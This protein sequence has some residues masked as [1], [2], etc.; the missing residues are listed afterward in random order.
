VEALRL[1]LTDDD[2]RQL[3]HWSEHYQSEWDDEP[4]RYVEF[5]V[6]GLGRS[7]RLG[8]L[9]LD[10]CKAYLGVQHIDPS[11]PGWGIFDRPQT[12]YFVSMFVADQCVALRTAGTLHG[13]L[14]VLSAFLASDR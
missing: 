5:G 13:A 4:E 14:D 8:L 1:E 12:R 10:G 7:R 9:K 2:L 3:V 11:K 6:V